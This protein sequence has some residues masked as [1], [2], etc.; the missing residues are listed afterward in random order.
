MRDPHEVYMNTLVPMVV[1]QSKRHA[2]ISTLLR[3]PHLVVCI[4]KM[5][6]VGW[7]EAAFERVKNEFRDFAMKLDVTDLTFIPVSA[8]HG[9]TVVDRLDTCPDERGDR[10]QCRL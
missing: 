6:L 5:D 3:I 2:F 1:E 9:D 10:S 7:D 4:N 8:L